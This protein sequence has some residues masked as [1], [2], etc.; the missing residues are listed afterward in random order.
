MSALSLINVAASQ[1]GRR[2]LDGVNL[3]VR[4]GEVLGVVGRN[5]AGKTSLLRVALGLMKLDAGTACLAGRDVAGLSDPARAALVAY[6]PQERRVGW[7]LPAW[8]IA[9]LG[10]P[11]KP[12]A[13]ARAAALAALERVGLAGMAERGVLDLSGGER[14]RALLARLLVTEA[15]LLLA[16]EP[17]AGLDP[18]AQ[19]MALDLLREE[20]A[21]GRAVMVTL[22]DLTL[23]CGPATGWRCWTPDGW[24]S[25]TFPNRR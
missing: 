9:S 2:V 8:R 15:P 20:A 3:E 10:A 22:H 14:A 21:K 7:N 16:D 11:E 18:D 17:T 25:W 12:P 23:Q 1:G 4:P 24:S 13:L 6:L 5:G 19:F